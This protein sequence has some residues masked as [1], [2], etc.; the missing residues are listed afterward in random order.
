MNSLFN[1]IND[2]NLFMI[3]NKIDILGLNETWLNKDISDSFLNIPGYQLERA[4]S[5][6]NVRK[7]GVAFYIRIDITYQRVNLCIPNLII[8]HLVLYNV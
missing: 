7:H 4:D 2:V 6:D 1:K 5:P 3:S 8:V